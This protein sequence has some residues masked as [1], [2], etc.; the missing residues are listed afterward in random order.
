MAEY[1]RHPDLRIRLNNPSEARIF[2]DDPRTWIPER[3]PRELNTQ[4]MSDE[5]AVYHAFM[6]LS[7]IMWSAQKEKEVLDGL[8]EEICEIH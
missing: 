2:I 7:K 5:D 1:Y 3:K 4:L 6:I 8:G